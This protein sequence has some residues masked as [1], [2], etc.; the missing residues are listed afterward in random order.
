MLLFLTIENFEVFRKVDGGATTEITDT[1]FVNLMRKWFTFHESGDDFIRVNAQG[2]FSRGVGGLTNIG[3]GKFEYDG[4][5]SEDLSTRMSGK[6]IMLTSEVIDEVERLIAYT[7]DFEVDPQFLE[8]GA[9]F[10]VLKNPDVTNDGDG[11]I[12]KLDGGELSDPSVGLTWTKLVDDGQVTEI[13]AEGVSVP[14]KLPGPITDLAFGD[15]TQDNFPS[16]FL[17][18]RQKDIS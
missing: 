16:P 17:L 8:G 3:E 7:L 13:D 18:F 5:I 14:L 15:P 12:K 9:E 2:E 1:F 6:P 11:F 4:T 10:E